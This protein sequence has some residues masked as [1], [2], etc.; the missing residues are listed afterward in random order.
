M[1]LLVSH[2]SQTS[3]Y[4]PEGVFLETAKKMGLKNCQCQ[5]IRVH[6]Y[7]HRVSCGGTGCVVPGQHQDCEFIFILFVVDIVGCWGSRN[8]T[9]ASGWDKNCRTGTRALRALDLRTK[10]IWYVST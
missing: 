5:I 1:I 3:G 2:K 10:L 6:L 9:V 7:Q 4:L 8:R